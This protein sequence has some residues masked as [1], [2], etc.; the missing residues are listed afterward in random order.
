M[1]FHH[2]FLP[3]DPNTWRRKEVAVGGGEDNPNSNVTDLLRWLNLTEDEEAVADF[4]DDEEELE[5]P[6]VEWAI[7]GKVLSPSPVHVNMVRSAM[8]LAWA[9]SVGLKFQAIGEKGDNLLVA[10]FGSSVD[11]EWALA[12]TP[13]M[14][15]R[16]AVI[17]QNYNE[18]LSASEIIFDRLE[19]WV[20]I[21]NL[22]LGWMSQMRGFSAMSL[23]GRVVKTNVEVD[24]KASGAFLRA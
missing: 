2:Q 12:T 16:Y 5:L 4:T 17:L 14:V 18:K 23:I 9:N 7:V 15:G 20:H 19:M 6:L 24:G 1:Q 10:E 8:K 13:W 22:P 3:S 21:L 11:M